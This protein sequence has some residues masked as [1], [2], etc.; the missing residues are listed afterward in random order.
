MRRL[1]LPP[2]P[3]L[4]IALIACASGRSVPVVSLGARFA[5]PQT[6]PGKLSAAAMGAT[7]TVPEGWRE[8]STETSTGEPLVQLTQDGAPYGVGIAVVRRNA[9]GASTTKLLEA[10]A[11]KIFVGDSSTILGPEALN[12]VA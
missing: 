10:H 5:P 2:V 9:T 11:A 7:F 6:L 3:L 4:M 8:T 12:P 1:A